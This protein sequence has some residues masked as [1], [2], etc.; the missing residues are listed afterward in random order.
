MNTAPYA[1]AAIVLFLCL[2]YAIK[3]VA[4]ARART[5]IATEGNS[6][7]VVRAML[8]GEEAK[9]RLAGLRWGVVLTCLGAGL[10]IVALVGWDEH[11]PTPVALAVIVGATG[12]GNLIFFALAQTLFR[13]TPAK[14]E[15]SP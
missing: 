12:I 5:R 13:P 1:V 6:P 8:A 2:A 7:E 9:R 4:D 15:T 10:G 3:S 11:G 14:D